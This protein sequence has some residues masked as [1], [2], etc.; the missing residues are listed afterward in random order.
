[1]AQENNP[2]D[3]VVRSV[4]S[5]DHDTA[6]PRTRNWA[7]YD[8][9]TL[10]ESVHA[11]NDPGQVGA[12]AQEWAV[13]GQDIHD[14]A[15]SMKDCLVAG[16]SGWQGVA[17]ESAR[18]AIRQLADWSEAAAYVADDLG[19]RVGEQG[20]IMAGAKAA[21]PEPVEFDWH[22][23][24]TN[25]F[26][27]GGMDGFAAA[28]VD[29]KAESDR[30]SA[31][32]QKAVAVM[33]EMEE[34][35]RAVDTATPRFTPPPDPV[36]RDVDVLVR[37]NSV[38]PAETPLSTSDMK[39]RSLTAVPDED[40][41]TG[42]PSYSDQP[43][44]TTP[45]T[46]VARVAPPGAPPVGV[47]EGEVY[48]QLDTAPQNARS[49]SAFTV[50]DAVGPNRY[51][52]GGTT[53]QGFPGARGGPGET[54]VRMPTVPAY[55]PGGRSRLPSGAPVLPP[56]VPGMPGNTGGGGDVLRRGWGPS[57]PA[58]PPPGGDPRARM[59][60]SAPPSAGPGVQGQAG[61]RSGAP[62]SGMPRNGVPGQ[63]GP[64]VPRSGVPG[65]ADAGPAAGRA[66]RD[67]TE[68]ETH[69]SRYATGER[70]FDAPDTGLPP[71][72][73]GGRTPR[74]ERDHGHRS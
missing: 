54:T 49:A 7:A 41:M 23:T 16:E 19:N 9:R 21:M 59:P 70:I 22:A 34:L 25:G 39:V 2:A 42:A 69:K 40:A 48:Q 66:R 45:R 1:M 56:P 8:H 24:L 32:H 61:P 43:D 36:A 35:S 72:V 14:A 67:G 60:T 26:A 18:H 10:Y 29:V 68:D 57:G 65:P 44:R 5:P 12:L 30:V 27:G 13:L 51:S 28:L 55:E 74:D 20:Q 52:P 53:P 58:T 37:W 31:A 50:P 71:A 6:L 4:D 15:Q 11:G 46:V 47:P 33:T 38:D 62:G 63:T 73:I 64:S 17:A 3:F